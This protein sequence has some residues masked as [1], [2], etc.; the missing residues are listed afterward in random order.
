MSKAIALTLRAWV[1]VV[2]LGIKE[3]ETSRS[4]LTELLPALFCVCWL[5]NKF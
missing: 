3:V 4:Q 1:L 5:K 2:D